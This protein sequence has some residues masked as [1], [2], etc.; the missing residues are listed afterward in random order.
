MDNIQFN[1]IQSIVLWGIPLLFAIT[2]HEVAHGYIANKLGDPTAKI[3]GRLTLNPGKHIDLIGTIIIPALTVYF[4]GFIF[5]WAKPVPITWRN[6]KHPRR[7]MALVAFAGPLANLLMAVMWALLAKA[8]DA[9]QLQQITPGIALEAM[10]K[11]GIYAN[12]MLFVLNLLP[13]Q[14]LDG[15]RIVSSLLPGKLRYYFDKLE[16]YGFLIILA[17]L[18]TNVLMMIL[19]L[20]L[21]FLVSGI[22]QLFGL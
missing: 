16:P 1:L 15:G 7:D 11:I 18:A 6:L 8:G 19:G 10:G 2:V 14:P 20:P 21:S 22:H 5:G 9:L 12:C 13:L 3:L 17:L 4:G